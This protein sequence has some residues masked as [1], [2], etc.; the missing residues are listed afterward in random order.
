M[1]ADAL[2]TATAAGENIYVPSICLVEL[3]YLIEKRRLPA[4]VR[5]QLIETLD[6]PGSPCSLVPLDRIVADALASVNRSEVADLPDRI[7]AATAVALHSP[8]I[9]RDA[10]VRASQIQTIW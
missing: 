8:L 1:A 9:S 7:I 6:D 4:L 5:D 3:T 10:K 2:D